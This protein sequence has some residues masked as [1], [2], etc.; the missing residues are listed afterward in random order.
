MKKY[1][2]HTNTNLYANVK[3]E[4]RTSLAPS[5]CFLEKKSVLICC[6]IA[7]WKQQQTDSISFDS[8]TFSNKHVCCASKITS[9]KNKTATSFN[10]YANFCLLLLIFL[11]L[12]TFFFCYVLTC[13]LSSFLALRLWEIGQ[14]RRQGTGFFS[15]RQVWREEAGQIE[16]KNPEGGNE[17]VSI[18]FSANRNACPPAWYMLC[19]NRFDFETQI[20]RTKRRNTSPCCWMLMDKCVIFFLIW[21]SWRDLL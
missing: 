5:S 18:N 3:S 1:E 17:C 4:A 11:S 20:D 7:G 2:N 12:F 21:W 9:T 14:T 10:S 13:L 19:E 15:C 16:K 8:S 6:P